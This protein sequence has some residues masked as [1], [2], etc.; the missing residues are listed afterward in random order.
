MLFPAPHAENIALEKPTWQIDDYE[1]YTKAPKAVDG[2]KNPVF[3]QK[4]CAC[5]KSNEHAWWSVDLKAEYDVTNV[6]ITNRNAAGTL[7]LSL[8]WCYNECDGVSN[9]RR[10]DCLL[11]R[12]LRRRSKKTLKLR[13]T[14]PCEANSLVTGEFPSQRASNAE[15][16]PFDD[17]IMYKNDTIP[18]CVI[19]TKQQLYWLLSRLCMDSTS[20]LERHMCVMAFQVTR[21]SIVCSIVCL[22]SSERQ[23]QEVGIT[24]PLWGESTGDRWIP[25]TKGQ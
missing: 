24:G 12:L 19:L 9:H 14:D 22:G 7:F 21:N 15:M 1:S 18:V 8:Q 6:K 23:T 25:L 20:F 16:V 2:N 3:N 10:L 17:V 13:V 4:S 5:T 11:N